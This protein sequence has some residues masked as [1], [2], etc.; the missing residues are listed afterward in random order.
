MVPLMI[1]KDIV[2]IWYDIPPIVM[3]GVAIAWI[4]YGM[5]KGM[6]TRITPLTISSSAISKDHKIVFV[7]DIHVDAIRDRKYIQSIVN[8]VKGIGP[9]LVLIGGDM[10]NSAKSSHVD[11]FLPFNQLDIPVYAT[12]GNHDH[13]GNSAALA[14]IFEKTNI[15]PLRNQS[16]DIHEIQIVGIDDKSYRGEK[17]LS[18]I[19][20][21]SV[22]IKDERFTV[23]V[24]HQPQHLK[25]LENHSINLQLAGHTHHG[26]FIPLTWI[27]RFFN[28]YA[29]GE[30]HHKK[31]TAFISQGIGSRGAPIRIGT[32][33]ELVEI[34]LKP[35]AKDKVS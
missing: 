25:K 32:Q 10:V 6:K 17:Q 30:Y 4:G 9:D 15:K 16:I 23:L 5:Y 21:E 28:D 8:A 22:S 13:M 1:L 24:S 19:L 34:T 12:L 2:S 20:D 18:E 31:M 7:S 26:Q 29:Y 27:I 3:I 14:E 11:A 35:V 33:S